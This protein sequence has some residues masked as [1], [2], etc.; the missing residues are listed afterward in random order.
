MEVPIW[1]P[2]PKEELRKFAETDDLHISPFREDGKTYGSP[3]W[4]WSV[5]VDDALYVRAY[6][7][8]NSRWYKAA[9]QQKAGRITA[10]GMT[11]EVTF[12]SIDGGMNDRIDD[13]YRAKYKE[14]SI[15][16]SHGR[17]RE[18]RDSEAD[19]ARNQRLN[20]GGRNEQTDLCKL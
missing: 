4:I 1:L 14:Q 20:F 16:E 2:W 10:A 12:E 6:N 17:R 15:S 5:V 18:V 3:T 7:G 9:M 8:Q 13:A 11:K 19:A